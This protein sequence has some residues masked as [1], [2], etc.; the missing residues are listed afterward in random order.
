MA[1]DQRL[2]TPLVRI[3]RCEDR[4]EF[5]YWEEMRTQKRRPVISTRNPEHKGDYVLMCGCDEC[6]QVP[7]AVK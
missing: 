2:S 5:C 3:M 4:P 7:L 6:V 1:G